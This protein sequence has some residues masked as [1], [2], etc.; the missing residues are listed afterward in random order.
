LEAIGAVSGTESKKA[1]S[2][3]SNYQECISA[4][5]SEAADDLAVRRD[6]DVD[7]I[8]DANGISGELNHVLTSIDKLNTFG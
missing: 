4:P 3:G 1:T 7:D 8:D 5:L 6:K 2:R